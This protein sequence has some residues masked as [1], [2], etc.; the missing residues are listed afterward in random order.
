MCV[1][2]LD[3][4][5]PLEDKLVINL[6]EQVDILVSHQQNGE[7]CIVHSDI[8]ASD[9][10]LSDM[11]DLFPIV[12]VLATQCKGTTRFYG[13]AYLRFKRVI[14]SDLLS[15]SSVTWVPRYP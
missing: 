15:C 13:T 6:L 1:P 12:A 7:F 5:L 9:V 4:A 10:N 2:N 14:V 8:C 3:P 11:L